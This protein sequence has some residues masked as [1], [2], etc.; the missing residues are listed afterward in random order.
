LRRRLKRILIKPVHWVLRDPTVREALWGIVNSPPLNNL[1]NPPPLNPWFEVWA[2]ATRQTADYIEEKM[3]SVPLYKGRRILF[4]VALSSVKVD[5]LYLEFGCGW[6][7]KSINFLAERI[8]GTIHGFDSFEG[9]PEPW[10]G[11][12]TQGS[13]TSHG[14]LPKVRKNVKLHAGRFDQTLPEFITT[15]DD[16]VAFMHIDCDIYSSA[17]IVFDLLGSKIIPGTVIQ[18]DEYFNYP[19]WK[20]HEFKVF[21]EFIN[22]RSLTYDYLGY[23]AQFAVAVLIK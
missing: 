3:M 5:G 11:H 20:N 15:H 7:A 4:E 16:P 6:E 21:Q 18:F 10:F 19:G 14:Q 23:T 9:L 2:N 1:G 13:L 17:K 22:K 12:L 8:D